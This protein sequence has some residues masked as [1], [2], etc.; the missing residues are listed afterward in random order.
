MF[1]RAAPDGFKVIIIE[2][3]TPFF[4][5]LVVFEDSFPCGIS[6]LLPVLAHHQVEEADEGQDL[7]NAV[8][9]V[10]PKQTHVRLEAQYEIKWQSKQVRQ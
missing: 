4:D 8:A 2:V 1:S 6:D 10:E 5:L 9:Q 7:H 3:D